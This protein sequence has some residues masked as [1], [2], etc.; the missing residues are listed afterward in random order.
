[1]N[2]LTMDLCSTSALMQQTIICWNTLCYLHYKLVIFTLPSL[3]F[4][5]VFETTL[6]S[7]FKLFLF[8]S[9]AW[10]TQVRLDHAHASTNFFL[11]LIFALNSV[12][13][14]VDW[15]DFA[16]VSANCCVVDLIFLDLIDATFPR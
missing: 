13:T 8:G 12:S 14:C 1:M 15:L 9:Y 6:F 16:T 11:E 4:H 2:T 7:F 5:H 3:S 10:S